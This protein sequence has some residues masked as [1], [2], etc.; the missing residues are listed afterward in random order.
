MKS[1]AQL[2]AERADFVATTLAEPPRYDWIER[3]LFRYFAVARFHLPNS[4]C[5]LRNATRRET[6]RARAGLRAKVLRHMRLQWL[7]QRADVKLSLPLAGRPQLIVIRLSSQPPDVVADAAKQ[8]IDC[9]TPKAG[10]FGIIEDDSPR[11]IQRSE[12]WEWAPAG[13]GFT[14]IEVRI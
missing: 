6:W 8:A 12:W 14:W 3:P 5:P 13:E 2:T 10:G 9:L 11:H 7:A 1:L 4:L